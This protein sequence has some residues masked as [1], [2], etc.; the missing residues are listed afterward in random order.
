M[1]GPHHSSRAR[2]SMTIV[3]AVA[4][5]GLVAVVA[6]PAVYAAESTLTW[7]TKSDMPTSRGRV[8]LATDSGGTVYA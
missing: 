1:T 3:A 4:V 5:T 2:K 6:P 8:G 7:T